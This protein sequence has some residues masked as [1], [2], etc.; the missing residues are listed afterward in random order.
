MDLTVL[1]FYVKYITLLN[2]SVGATVYNFCDR[3]TAFQID[4]CQ[5]Y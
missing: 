4:I 2:F 5:T 3:N 1:H